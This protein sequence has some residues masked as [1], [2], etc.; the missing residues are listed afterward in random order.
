MCIV[1]EAEEYVAD[2]WSD[3]KE[4]PLPSAVREDL[5]EAL[6]E[7]V[8]EDSNYKSWPVFTYTDVVYGCQDGRTPCSECGRL[9]LRDDYLC[10]SC[11]G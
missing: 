8:E 7:H 2:K 11:R 9:A 5:R 3:Q 1:C 4:I 6:W 10:S